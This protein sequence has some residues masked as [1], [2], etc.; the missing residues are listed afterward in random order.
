MTKP[1][2]LDHWSHDEID[3]SVREMYY[4]NEPWPLVTFLNKWKANKVS[5][6]APAVIQL[7]CAYRNLVN[8]NGPRPADAPAK[9][10]IRT[11]ERMPTARNTKPKA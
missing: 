2:F 11:V 4:S 1:T 3:R 7:V 8:A 6:P 10:W 9:G 5:A